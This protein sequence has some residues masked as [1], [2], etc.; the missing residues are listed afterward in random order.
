M[1]EEDGSDVVEMAVEGKKATPGLVRPDFNLVVVTTRN[2]KRLRL[3]KV[4]AADGTIVLFKAINQ[5]SHSI[6]PELDGGRVQ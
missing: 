3:V 2:K 4:H 1:V 5:S 6:I